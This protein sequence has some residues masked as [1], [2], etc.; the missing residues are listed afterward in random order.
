MHSHVCFMVLVL[1]RFDRLQRENVFVLADRVRGMGFVRFRN[2]LVRIRDANQIHHLTMEK[3]H[4]IQTGRLLCQL[5]GR[6]V[7]HD[8]L[9]HRRSIGVRNGDN[10]DAV[11]EILN[12]DPLSLFGFIRIIR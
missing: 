11:I 10:V 9:S 4:V 12:L 2:N 8:P 3:R 1:K 7:L 6:L 5:H